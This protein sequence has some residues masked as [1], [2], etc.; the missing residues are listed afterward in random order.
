MYADPFWRPEP[1]EG[2]AGALKSVQVG[3]APAIG[4]DSELEG[5]SLLQ[6]AFPRS[7]ASSAVVPLRLHLQSKRTIPFYKLNDAKIENFHSKYIQI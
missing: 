3:L 4:F 7:D 5:S 2:G 1:R 6:G